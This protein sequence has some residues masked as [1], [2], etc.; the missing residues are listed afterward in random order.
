MSI[1]NTLI[2]SIGFIF[3]LMTPAFI[4][5]FVL[6]E[7]IIETIFKWNVHHDKDSIQ[8]IHRALIFYSPGLIILVYQ[9]Y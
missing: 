9:N 6:S 5:L 2:N 4:G 8:H 3:Y 1:S 7:P